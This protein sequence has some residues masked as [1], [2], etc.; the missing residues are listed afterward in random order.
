MGEKWRMCE[1]EFA[2]FIYENGKPQSESIKIAKW[3]FTMY[4]A[5]QFTLEVN[6][7]P[8]LGL[9]SKTPKQNRLKELRHAVSNN[10]FL[11]SIY[12]RINPYNK[13]ITQP[14]SMYFSDFKEV[15]DFLEKKVGNIIH[16]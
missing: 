1:D 5:H 9:S 7:I 11:K 12:T 6:S 2:K 13:D 15:K 10:Y 16:A 8:M 4:L 14:R 3:I